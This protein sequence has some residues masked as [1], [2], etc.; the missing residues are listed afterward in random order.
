MEIR[1][2]VEVLGLETPAKPVGS[3]IA[4]F[5]MIERGL[6]VR[7]LDRVCY[8]FAPDDKSFKYRIVPKASLA[9]SQR[10]KRLTRQQSVTV[11]RLASVWTE[12][13]RIWKSEDAARDF[14]HRPHALLGD[15][16]PIDLIL[17]NEVGAELVKGALGKLEN[18]SAV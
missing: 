5:E 6:P 1:K 17:E 18:G 15:R 3:D 10:S 12:T 9:R 7:S 13:V 14:L 11:S 16:R 2:A 4:Y 8:V